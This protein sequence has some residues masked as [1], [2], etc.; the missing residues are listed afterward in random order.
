ML[1]L[2]SLAF[3]AK[4]WFSYWLNAVDRHSLQAPFIFKFYTEVIRSDHTS[5]IDRIEKVRTSLLKSDG[6]VNLID[7]GAG[8]LVIQQ[9]IRNIKDIARS[10][11]SQL[12]FSILLKNTISYFDFKC[13]LELG[14]SFGINTLYM[15]SCQETHIHT[16]E[17]SPEI[18]NVAKSSFKQANA[19]NISLHEG[20]IDHILP[21]LLKD[22]TKIDLVYMDANHTYEATIRYFEWLLP[23]LHSKSIVFIDDIYWS[24][25][26]KRAWKE[27]IDH[28]KV[29][30]SI[31][32]FDAG[33]LFFQEGLQK[34]NYILSF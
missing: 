4:E 13:I 25:G 21:G 33:I 31:D 19:Q 9:D 26:M 20:N 17:G 23:R 8:S 10:S 3:L 14:T 18:A 22:L 6:K 34:Q 7:P 24:P 27:I 29:R 5:K 16:I 1:S 30:M 2:K 12:K 28:P 15:A 32:I 11:T